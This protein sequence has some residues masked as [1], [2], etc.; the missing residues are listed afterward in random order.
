MFFQKR[1]NNLMLFKS[2]V[3]EA[4]PGLIHGFSSRGGG[5]SNGGYSSLN[6]GL[7]G[8]DKPE[9]V[10]KNRMLFIDTLGIR[11]NQVVCGQQVHSTNIVCVG[12]REGGRGFLNA[13][14]ALPE[15]DGLVTNQSGVALM[16]LYADCVPILFY[17]PI[18]HVIGVCHCG[19]RGTV[20]EIAKKMVDIMVKNYECMPSNICAAIGPSIS[21]M[22]Y[23]VDR[24][25]LE[26][27]YQTFS[28][29]DRVITKTDTEHGMLDLWEANRL[30]LLE[31]GIL[32][33]HI[34]VSGLCTFQNRQMFFSHRG[35]GGKTGRNAAVLMM[36]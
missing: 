13:M 32:D 16:T 15:T 26:T 34:D 7:A 24:P 30:Q 29:A 10:R 1:Q 25:V 31:A 23:E 5:Y 17:A 3:L 14:D 11:P 8:E 18:H 20:G 28:F 9:H 2:S 19:W 6:L 27:F 22:V 33:F 36:Q 35:D 4:Q 12:K 21:K